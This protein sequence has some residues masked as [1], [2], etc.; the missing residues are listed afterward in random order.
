MERR[1]LGRTGISV[2]VLG[3]GAGMFGQFGQ[4]TEETCIRVVHAALDGGINL[5][6]TADFYSSGESETIVGAALKGRRDKVVLATKCGLPMGDDPNEKGASRR[7]I[8]KSVEASLKRL[9]TDYIDLYQMHRPDPDTDIAESLDALTTLVREGKIRAFGSSTFPAENIVE[10]QLVAENKG[11]IGLHSEQPPYSIFTRAIEADVLAVCEKHDVAVLAYTP[12]DGGWLSGKYR[13]NQ[14]AEVSARQRLQPARFDS[15]GDI[16]Q[17]KLDAVED[18]T[19]LAEEAGI[20]LSHMGIAF[21]LQHPAVTTALVGGGKVAYMEKHLA[22]VDVRLTDDI[23]DRID[24]I[25]PPGVNM[26]P[27]DRGYVPSSIMDKTLR[28]RART[29]GPAPS[30]AV[31]SSVRD[32]AQGEKRK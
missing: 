13:R 28:R 3:V 11:L 10:A 2:S 6:D 21:V 17:R 30:A 26:N 24:E 16:N 25:V 23:L 9:Q 31:G 32:I 19:A 18:L 27:A 22:G 14:V 8:M 7:W 1:I 12:L 5:V 20:E 4:T 15:E 29:G